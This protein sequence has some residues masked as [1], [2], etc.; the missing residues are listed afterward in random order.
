MTTLTA[1]I[2]NA[3]TGYQDFSIG[4]FT[5]RRNEYFAYVDYPD[6]EYVMPIDAFFESTHA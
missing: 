5:F 2:D 4:S 6:G 1:T 3:K